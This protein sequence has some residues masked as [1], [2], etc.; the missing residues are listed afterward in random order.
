MNTLA[1]RLRSA[2]HDIERLSGERT[3][4]LSVL[5][6]EDFAAEAAEFAS[7]SK[8][9]WDGLERAFAQFLVAGVPA[10]F[11]SFEARRH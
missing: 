9:F 1:D 8:P 10:R 11:G 2:D 7:L 6:I 3:R 4:L 5:C